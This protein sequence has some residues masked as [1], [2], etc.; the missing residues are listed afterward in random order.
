MK[1][2]LNKNKDQLWL[3]N[4]KNKGIGPGPWAGP[5]IGSLEGFRRKKDTSCLPQNLPYYLVPGPQM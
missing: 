3:I 2:R 4:T 1:T 5:K